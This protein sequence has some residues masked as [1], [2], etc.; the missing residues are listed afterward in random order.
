MRRDF[1]IKRYKELLEALLA[2]GYL[3]KRVCGFNANREMRNDAKRFII[4]RQDVDKSPWNSLAFARIQKEF[5]IKSTFY[6][7]S[8]PRS[9][10]P[11]VIEEIAGFG[12]EI[13]YHYEDVSLT[14]CSSKFRVSGFKFREKDLIEESIVKFI[15]SLEKFR[16]IVPVKSICMHGS[17]MSKW[18]SRLLWK[19]YDY[20]EFG[21]ECEPY[22]DV[23]FENMLYLTDTGRRWNGAGVSVRDKAQSIG[24][25]AQNL[26]LSDLESERRRDKNVEHG[27]LNPEQFSDWKV[28]PVLGSLMNMTEK[29]C[30]FQSRYNF[31]STNDI[32][33]AAGKGELPDWMVFTFHPQRWTDKAVPWVR[34]LV[35]QNT[36]NVGKYFIVKIR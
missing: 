8:V 6:F 15:R 1:T 14:A 22:F 26:R 3:F 33:F 21:V 31:R 23:N 32:I 7:R 36:K 13:G 9:F 17:P 24:H 4:L 18:D 27:T 34:E 20:R 5:E 25:R 12:H 11:E 16:R 2:Q 10:E 35:W 29:S 28:K 19:Y 30:E